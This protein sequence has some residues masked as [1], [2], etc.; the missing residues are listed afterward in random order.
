MSAMQG[1]VATFKRYRFLLYNLVRR[2]FTVK[3]RRS[4]LGV[5]WSVLNPLLMMLVMWSVFSIL[6]SNMG[7]AGLQVVRATGQPPQFAVY[8]LSGQLIFTFFSEATQTAMDSVLS[9]ASLIKKVYVPKYMF[10][11]EKVLFSS[12]NALFSL[13]A[14]ALVML[15]TGSPISGWVALFWLP[16]LL[17]ALFNFGV[18]LLLAALTVFFRDIKHFYSIIVLALNY[19]TPIF[20]TEE[21][22]IDGGML[23]QVMYYVL[24]VNPLFWFVSMFRRLVVYGFGPTFNQLLA[25]CGWA[26]LAVILG[27]YM[28]KKTQDKFILYI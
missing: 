3:Y 6:F 27:L 7:G 26:V 12:L 25:C 22:F 21:I 16:L 28:F 1:I 10:P 24:R 17:L 15:V 13:I 20:Y 14:L 11:L 5:L 9:N 18:G 8:L 2:D 4:V 19:L 23:G